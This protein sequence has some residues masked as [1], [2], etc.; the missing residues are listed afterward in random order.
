MVRPQRLQAQEAAGQLWDKETYL[1]VAQD[2][3]SEPEVAF[4]QQLLAD[5]DGRGVKL[6]WGRWTTPGVSGHYFVAG[7]DTTVWIMNL[8]KASLELR[9][10]WIARSLKENGYNYSRLEK[11][12]DLLKGVAGAKLEEAAKKEWKGSI[13]LPLSEIVPGHV[14]EVMSA[15]GA[16]I[17]QTEPS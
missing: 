10:L 7:I 14:Q 17:D 11:A 15:I 16:I 4:I 2:Q 3:V 5:V 12:A 13:F 8:S 1:Q 9:L 6:G